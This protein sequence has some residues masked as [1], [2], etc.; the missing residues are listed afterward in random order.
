MIEQNEGVSP[1]LSSVRV[2]P[3]IIEC[4]D[5]SPNE[6][7]A[8]AMYLGRE[9]SFLERGDTVV[10]YRE[11]VGGLTEVGAQPPIAESSTNHG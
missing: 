2:T 11:S 6:L 5:Y 10:F 1:G 3:D 8:V 9:Y 7:R 4:H